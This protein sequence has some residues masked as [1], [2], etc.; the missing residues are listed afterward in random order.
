[1]GQQQGVAEP[2]GGQQGPQRGR[3]PSTGQKQFTLPTYKA[4]GTFNYPTANRELQRTCT[5]CLFMCLA[6]LLTLSF[7]KS[8]QLSVKPILKTKPLKNKVLKPRSLIWGTARIWTHVC[9][10]QGPS[11]EP[12]LHPRKKGSQ[13]LAALC[14]FNLLP[15]CEIPGESINFPV[16]QCSHL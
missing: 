2:A 3:L 14:S 16:P 8:S 4:S 12:K 9:C 7:F 1:M 6:F 5:E 10:N 13:R 11:S 15:C